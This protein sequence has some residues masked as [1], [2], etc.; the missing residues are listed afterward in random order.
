MSVERIQDFRFPRKKRVVTNS[1][2]NKENE[3]AQINKSRRAGGGEYST[4]L[5]TRG[6]EKTLADPLSEPEESS[7]AEES[8]TESEAE[9]ESETE[10]HVQEA[11][12]RKYSLRLRKPAVAESK[13]KAL[14]KLAVLRRTGRRDAKEKMYAEES[15]EEEEER[16]EEE[17]EEDEIEES[18]WN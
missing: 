14:N 9:S 2:A 18:V 1:R 5:R 6:N 17:E 15:E 12:E 3:P 11:Q 8:V 4:R 16:E 7:A 13:T 10:P